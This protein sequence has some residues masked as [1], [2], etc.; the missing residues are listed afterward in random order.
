[1][2]NLPD[3]PQI[4]PKD[5]TPFRNF[6]MTIGEIPSSYLESMS[7]AEMLLWFCDYLKNTIIPTV[8][9]NAEAVAELQDLYVELKNYVDNYF[10]NLDVQNEINNKLDKM[11]QN[12]TLENIMKPYF[13]S[14]QTSLD[15]FKNEIDEE[16]DDTINNL[17]SGTPLVASSTS[18]MTDTSRIYVNTTDG[19][20][21]Y[22]KDN[23]WTD[24]GVYQAT[25]IG[26]REV[27]YKNLN[28]VFSD[29]TQMF[30]K[31]TV[32]YDKYISNSTGNE[33]T[34]TDNYKWACSDFI[35]VE[36][37]HI[38]SRTFNTGYWTRAFYDSNK[39]K[40][41]YSFNSYPLTP[42]VPPINAKYFRFS[43]RGSTTE[44][45]Q[46][47][48]DNFVFNEGFVVNDFT[49][50]YK[51][52]DDLKFIRNFNDG[53]GFLKIYSN[54]SVNLYNNKYTSKCYIESNGGLNFPQDSNNYITTDL[55]ECSN[56]K[57]LYLNTNAFYA[58]EWD[59]NYNFLNRTNLSISDVK[60]QF[61]P[62]NSKTK[63]VAFT[64]TSS[65]F[66]NTLMISKDKK[67]KYYS[68]Q[69]VG[70]PP[71]TIT[72]DMLADEIFSDSNFSNTIINFL[73]DSITYGYDGAIPNNTDNIRVKKPY[74]E[75]VK[76]ILGLLKA[77]NYGVSGASISGESYP[78]YINY[79]NMTNNADYVI[80]FAGTN[81]WSG[82]IYGQPLGEKTDTEAG[83]FYGALDILIK[84]LINKYPTKKIGFITPIKRTAGGDTNK[85]NLHL[86]DYVDA[87]IYK[88]NEFAIP[89]LNFFLNSGCCPQIDI[90]KENNLPDGLHPNQQYYNVLGYKIAQFIKTL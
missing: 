54:N 32:T 52:F 71:K 72:K 24:G 85:Y 46:N 25:E 14:F 53:V 89:V 10:N 3:N 16:I 76:E 69:I 62:T 47:I 37:F 33:A 23:S 11:A 45:L 44:E 6:C 67:D 19:H 38:Y 79:T 9:N 88:C 49:P 74:P 41:D 84:G 13:N 61:T 65:N 90:F 34:P 26:N 55:I 77:N 18:Q 78:L 36:A 75:T 50:Y 31:E 29:N 81:D 5:L 8:N 39:Q 20:W 59:E 22:Y 73:G 83:T 87:I 58:G 30:N 51:N 40:I 82:S 43:I 66:I 12:G 7:Y 56:L 17:T 68:N 64:L 21:Y 86:S 60:N 48:I 42:I 35:P 80:V 1:M 2:N 70:I 63:Y 15:D 28:Y 27:G 4:K 57:T